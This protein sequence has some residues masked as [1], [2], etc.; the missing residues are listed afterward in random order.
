MP[1]CKPRDILIVKGNIFNKDQCPK[2]EIERVEMNNK[3]LGSAL[4]NL[5]YAQVCTRPDIAFI[6]G[7][8]CRYQSNLE[9]DH[10]I[11]AKKVMRYL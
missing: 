4:G 10:W 6:V 11:T 1:N 7:V 2:K 8:L 9:N 5:I 3:P